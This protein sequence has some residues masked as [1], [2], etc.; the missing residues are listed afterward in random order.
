M[1]GPPGS[2]TRLRNCAYAAATSR[3]RDSNDQTIPPATCTRARRS[4]PPASSQP[5]PPASGSRPNDPDVHV[6]HPLLQRPRP[7]QPLRAA[8][9]T[10]P[11]RP[12]PAPTPTTASPS[13]T[14]RP[15]DQAVRPRISRVQRRRAPR[16]PLRRVL[17]RPHQSRSRAPAPPA[18]PPPS[19]C[20]PARIRLPPQ[21]IPIH[22]RHERL[23]LLQR[24][25]PGGPTGPTRASAAGSTARRP[26]R[27]PSTSP[28]RRA[29]MCR[30]GAPARSPPERR[31][32][33]TRRVTVQAVVAVGERLRVGE[34]PLARD[35]VPGDRRHPGQRR[36]ARPGWLCTTCRARSA[37]AGQVPAVAV[38]QSRP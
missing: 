33:T 5:R 36:P 34:G 4:R 31:R 29:G 32:S 17:Q 11:A 27:P 13:S 8:P 6:P 25:R 30:P 7:R 12:S 18:A 28:P 24:A 22:L 20:S 21:H 23:D 10:P 38:T 3:C 19:D 37:D 1:P 14:P 35:G 16:H 2:G 26:R 9:R 15:R